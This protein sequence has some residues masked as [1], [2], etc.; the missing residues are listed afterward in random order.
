MSHIPKIAQPKG[1]QTQ[2]LDPSKPKLRIFDPNREEEPEKKEEAKNPHNIGELIHPKFNKFCESANKS[3]LP[4]A[5]A[6]WPLYC[7][8]QIIGFFS[9]KIEHLA[10]A[11]YGVCWAVVYSCYRPWAV[12]RRTLEGD[13][14]S[15]SVKNLYKANEHFRAIMGTAVTAVY[16]GGALGMLWSWIKGDDNLFDRASEFYK[17]GMLNQNQ[18]FGSMNTTVVARRKYN[19]E[20][21]YPIDRVGNDYKANIELVDTA[22]FIPNIITRAIDTFRLFGMEISEGLQRIVDGL[23][24]LC[25]GTWA[26]RYGLLKSSQASGGDLAKLKDKKYAA[27]KFFYNTQGKSS[28]LFYTLLPGLSWLAAIAEF[29]G[30]SDFA[31]QVFSWEGK[32]ERLLPTIASWVIRDTWLKW[33]GKAKIPTSKDI[34]YEEAPPTETKKSS[35]RTSTH[36]QEVETTKPVTKEMKLNAIK[37]FLNGKPLEELKVKITLL[38]ICTAAKNGEVTWK[39]FINACSKGYIDWVD[40]RDLKQKFPELIPDKVYDEAF[41]EAYIAS[42]EKHHKP[43]RKTK[44][45]S[46]EGKA[47]KKNRD[48]WRGSLTKKDYYPPSVT[49]APLYRGELSDTQTFFAVGDST[50]VH[51]TEAIQVIGSYGMVITPLDR[52]TNEDGLHA[53]GDLFGNPLVV[54]ERSTLGQ[55]IL[56]DGLTNYVHIRGT[57]SGDVSLPLPDSQTISDTTEASGPIFV[58]TPGGFAFSSEDLTTPVPSI[59]EL[60]VQDVFTL[61]DKELQTF[62]EPDNSVFTEHTVSQF[63]SDNDTSLETVTKDKPES[64]TYAPPKVDGSH[65]TFSYPR[66]FSQFDSNKLYRVQLYLKG[67]LSLDEDESSALKDALDTVRVG[68]ISHDDIFDAAEKGYISLSAID[69][70]E[71]NFPLYPDEIDKKHGIPRLLTEVES[72]AGNDPNT[73]HREKGDKNRQ[74]LEIEMVTKRKSKLYTH[75]TLED[76][77]TFIRPLSLEKVLERK[78]HTRIKPEVIAFNHSII[79]NYL[80]PNQ[81]SS[82]QDFPFT[83]NELSIGIDDEGKIITDKNGVP[84]TGS[85][86]N[87]I[88]SACD[89][90]LNLHENGAVQVEVPSWFENKEM[91]FAFEDD[92]IDTYNERFAGEV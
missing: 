28:H 70:N 68:L 60:G 48:Y 83:V 19:P 44:T 22:L 31:K 5:K 29:F 20:Q 47:E 84:L 78:K 37:D 62:V 63:A 1:G 61:D 57:N 90:N 85:Q 64:K 73:W 51:T 2:R 87:N 30:Y 36:G 79:Q 89:F 15:P 76:L 49:A 42:E 8:L 45:R 50:L 52:T 25:Y 34:P 41:D 72:F 86:L 12:N 27:D 75:S 59:E 33:A 43:H 39:E 74:H 66:E 3:I 11:W 26:T 77:E 55:T 32:C 56:P 46:E 80:I 35:P 10:R 9:E 17:T 53:I 88:Q 82:A 6:I 71:N 7:P 4:V 81:I 67:E 54:L 58:E 91:L 92:V 18:I 24:Y 69:D 38:D 14:A 23:G 65:S 40:L 21:L 13:K 16:G